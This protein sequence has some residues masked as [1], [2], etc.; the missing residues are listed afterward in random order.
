MWF[1]RRIVG[2]SANALLQT[3]ESDILPWN[4][5]E[6]ASIR[7]WAL[8]MVHQSPRHSMPESRYWQCCRLIH[9]HEIGLHQDN[10]NIWVPF[11][12]PRRIR[13]WFLLSIRDIPV[14]VSV[15]MRVIP[16]A[17]SWASNIPPTHHCYTGW[18]RRA[19][20]NKPDRIEHTAVDIYSRDGGI[21]S[22]S[23]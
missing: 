13:R 9:T 20:Q 18:V 6:S 7:S 16:T 3:S 4:W 23:G 1:Y 21:K 8:L 10:D 14:P 5:R 22:L 11:L 17:Y 12:W 2:S 19:T 15:V